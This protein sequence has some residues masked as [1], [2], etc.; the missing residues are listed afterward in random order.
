MYLVCRLLLEKKNFAINYRFCQ[1]LTR[2]MR[3][4]GLICLA[5]A[6]RP[7]GDVGHVWCMVE[8]LLL[9]VEESGEHELRRQRVHRPEQRDA[10]SGSGTVRAGRDQR[11]TG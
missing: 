1:K 4:S 11:R 2:W 5:R 6:S 3:R 8:L 7:G 9:A 10:E